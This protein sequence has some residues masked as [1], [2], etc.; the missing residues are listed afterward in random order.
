MTLRVT[1]LN[2]DVAG[3][4]DPTLRVT[5]LNV[6]VAG[7]PDPTLRVTRVNVDVA[8]EPATPDIR[9]YRHAIYVLLA[10][11]PAIEETASDS[12]IFDDEID[13]EQ[14]YGINQNVI[15]DDAAVAEIT[16]QPT[17]EQNLIL[18]Q[19]LPEPGVTIPESASNALILQQIM[20]G[21]LHV[22]SIAQSL[23][24]SQAAAT[25]N[26]T[27]YNEHV[28]QTLVLTDAAISSLQTLLAQNG[29]VFTQ[30]ALKTKIIE[31]G[32]EYSASSG[33]VFT[34]AATKVKILAVAV[35]KS[36]TDSLVFTSRATLP[37]FRVTQQT[38]IFAQVVAKD[39]I[40]QVEHDLI[41]TQEASAAGT[42]W[43]R[44]ASNGLVFTQ[45]IVWEDVID[46][47]NYSPNIGEGTGPTPP[48]S[49]IPTLTPQNFVRLFYP[50]TSPTLEVNIRTPEFGNRERLQ[51]TRINRESRGGTLQIF[52]DPTWPKSKVLALTFTGLT[53]S[54][55]QAVQ[56]FFT[57]TL[58]LEVGLTDWEGRTWHGVVTTPDADLVRSR[59]GRDACGNN[60]IVDLSFEFEGELQ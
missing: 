49:T 10:L 1:R 40:H 43:N 29:L 20:D 39:R 27:P 28:V 55:A 14:I 22:E 23:I 51:F 42:V 56:S 5:R 17:L 4:T 50:T 25:T 38:L 44:T 57:D 3:L 15:F 34:D 59:R 18:G 32:L 46:T 48:A 12:L 6:D 8:G 47:C 36:A 33:L 11:E 26:P 53:E 21:S 7:E 16:L 60:S 13:V 54:Q 31:G 45:A 58:G 52:A 37:V 35:D 19:D 9:V 41:F 24:F 2:T 30:Q